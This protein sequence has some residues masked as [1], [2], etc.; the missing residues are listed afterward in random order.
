MFH[1]DVKCKI[2]DRPDLIE[3][4][5]AVWVYNGS[6]FTLLV[7]LDPDPKE[8]TN[9]VWAV[10]KSFA[11][12]NGFHGI[13]GLNESVL[14]DLRVRFG[15]ALMEYRS[16]HDGAT[17]VPS[18]PIGMDWGKPVLPPLVKMPWLTDGVTDRTLRT[19][20]PL[21]ATVRPVE[22]KEVPMTASEV[23]KRVFDS[24]NS[25][26]PRGPITF[27][28][29][30]RARELMREPM[31]YVKDR[32]KEE[33]PW[34]PDDIAKTL[35]HCIAPDCDTMFYSEYEGEMCIHCREVM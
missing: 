34:S 16:A 15:L 13:N 31:E 14:T 23:E 9:H 27:D 17:P 3:T 29:I 4:V 5:D 18:A 20:D 28:D 33:Y 32:L 12:R 25:N 8:M 1:E 22:D 6:L 11:S 19:P 35:V 24:T 21:P 10:Y 26:E 7:S 30:Q 2:N